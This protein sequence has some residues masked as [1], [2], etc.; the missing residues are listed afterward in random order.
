MIHRKK[1]PV[2]VYII[3]F[4][5]AFVVAV[6]LAIVLAVAA[7]KPKLPSVMPRSMTYFG[8]MCSLNLY[9]VGTQELYNSLFHRLEE[10]EAEFDP[11]RATS[12]I[13]QINAAAGDHAVSV[14]QDIIYVLSRALSYAQL[15]DGVFDPTIGPIVELWN[16]GTD[17]AHLPNQRY[18]T[19]N[20]PL[21]DWREVAIEGDTVFLQKTG[22]ALDLGAIVKGFAADELCKI[23]KSNGVKKAIIDLGG[24]IYVY[25]KK[26]DNEPW[27]VGIKNPDNTEGDPAVV[28]PLGECSVVTSGVYERFFYQKGK[29][30]HHIFDVSTGYPLET[31]LLSATVICSSSIDADAL[32][33]LVFLLGID[34]GI[35]LLDRMDGVSGVFINENHEIIATESLRG[36]LESPSYKYK[37]IRYR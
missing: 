8:T 30:Y 3:S 12:D 23:L 15:S 25:G 24:N 33:T 10:I 22:M 28:L 2:Y 26:L 1:T 32:S 7:R 20:L 5:S 35:D 37:V 17:E 34:K 29:R 31:E 27:Y 11:H 6:C 13:S 18:I 19:A 4:L 21:V 16:I 36:L 9:E 14:N